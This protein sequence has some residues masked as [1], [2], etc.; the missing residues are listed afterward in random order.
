MAKIYSPRIKK[1]VCGWKNSGGQH[2]VIACIQRLWYSFWCFQCRINEKNTW[3]ERI[4]K[5]SFTSF[6]RVKRRSRSDCCCRRMLFSA[7][8][9]VSKEKKLCIVNSIL[10]HYP[11]QETRIPFGPTTKFSLVMIYTRVQSH[12]VG[13]EASLGLLLWKQQ[14]IR[15]QKHSGNSFHESARGGAVEPEG[16][17]KQP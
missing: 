12:G 4:C 15:H 14:V 9:G 7:L 8:C 17:G 11:L 1:L 10:L 2:I 3:K 5:P 6:Q 16:V 13:K